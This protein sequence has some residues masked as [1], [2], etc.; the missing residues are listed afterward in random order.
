MYNF[1]LGSHLPSSLLATFFSDF[2]SFIILPSFLQKD[3][4]G[5]GR[6]WIR[7][8]SNVFFS[9][10]NIYF[11]ILLYWIQF[12]FT[13]IV[14]FGSVGWTCLIKQ[15]LGNKEQCKTHLPVL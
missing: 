10:V 11:T 8:I 3:L 6:I 1:T 12:F 15:V 5:F 14:E 13:R 2:F 9:S 4:S 7:F